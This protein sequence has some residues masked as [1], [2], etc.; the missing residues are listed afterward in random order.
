MTPE[1][2]LCGAADAR[3]MLSAGEW[4]VLKCPHCELGWLDP[5]PDARRLAELYDEDYFTRHKIMT[6]DDDEQLARKVAGQRSWV[7][8]VRR[9]K[10]VGSLLDIGCASGYLLAR[11]REVGYEVRGIEVSEWAV[12][13]GRERLGLDIRQST[14]ESADFAP[15]SFDVITMLH[16][17]EH[18]E[19]PVNNLIKVR[20]WL[21]PDGVLIVACPNTNS[22][23]AA[24]YGAE[25]TGWS[26]PYHIW[27]F[28]PKSLG[29]IL[30]RARYEVTA[31]QTLPSKWVKDKLRRIPVVGLTRN[32]V[33]RWFSG[34]DMRLA[35][36]RRD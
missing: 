12:Q 13:Q 16:V 36:R 32:I 14:I 23:D 31:V 22:F 7:N 30:N 21:K 26:I 18:L 34:R 6:S 15:A 3:V 5:K 17:V 4:R 24:K 10:K 20:E 29:I 2:N 1:C 33:C 25:W 19:E 9:H 11:A 35:A 27:H 8:F 28:T